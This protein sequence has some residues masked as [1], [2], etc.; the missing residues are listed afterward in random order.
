MVPV[1]ATAAKHRFLRLIYN[2]GI[3]SCE[4]G[5]LS[6]SLETKVEMLSR[7]KAPTLIFSSYIKFIPLITNDHMFITI[8]YL[9]E[10]VLLSSSRCGLTA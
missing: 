5:R 7:I 3:P 6:K 8:I 4:N 1:L 2:G 9:N 10:F